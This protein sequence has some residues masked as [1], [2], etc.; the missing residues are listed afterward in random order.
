MMNSLANIAK[1]RIGQPNPFPSLSGFPSNAYAAHWGL[2]DLY[3]ED[4]RILRNAIDKRKTF[5][6]G[7]VGCKKEIHYFRIISD[8]KVVTIQVS[9]EMDDYED[10]IYDA[11]ETEVELT[12]DQVDELNNYWYESDMDSYTEAETTV[13]V[14]T[15]ENVME[16]IEKMESKTD[17]Q[18]ESW[19]EIVKT[20]VKEVTER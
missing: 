6:T 8:G 20:W 5:D 14:T 12:D 2:T 16:I 9:A 17:T 4:E 10:L 13:P 7:W 19:F 15:Y 11:M 18:L 1:D 3:P